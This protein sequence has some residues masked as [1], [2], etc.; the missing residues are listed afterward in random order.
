MN[1]KPELELINLKTLIEDRQV[2]V[3]RISTES[4]NHTQC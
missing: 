3:G 1:T 2:S 4:E